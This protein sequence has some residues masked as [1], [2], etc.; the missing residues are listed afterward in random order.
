VIVVDTSAL[1]AILNK[2]PERDRFLDVLAND[3]RPVLSAVTLYETMLIA[4][5]RRGPDNLADLAGILETAE[6]EVVPFDADQARAS[7]TVYMRYGKGL[8]QAARLNLCDC[9]AYALAK[10][11]G[12][13]LLYKGEDFRA[14][15][16][17]AAG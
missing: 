8:H 17:V 9:V 6:A 14:T 10:H 4:S 16:I 1:L 11:L 15:D 3:D 2:E 13:P 7:Q 12:V 5:A